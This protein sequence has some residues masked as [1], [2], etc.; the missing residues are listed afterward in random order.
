MAGR[1]NLV[2]CH[3]P[4]V[5]VDLGNRIVVR[6]ILVEL[7]ESHRLEIVLGVED[8]L[9]AAQPYYGRRPTS[10]RMPDRAVG[11]AEVEHDRAG[12]RTLLDEQLTHRHHFPFD[13]LTLG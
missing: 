6:R 9:A 13:L 3:F 12:D 4:V 1:E 7:N 2:E 5:V 8:A 11:A 10:A